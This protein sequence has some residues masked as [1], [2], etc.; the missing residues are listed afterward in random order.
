MKER[1]VVRRVADYF[2]QMGYRTETEVWVGDRS[3]DLIGWRRSPRRLISVEAKIDRWRYGLWQANL[4]R[5]CSDYAYLAVVKNVTDRIDLGPALATGVGVLAV[6]GAVE[7]ILPARYSRV[8]HPSLYHQ[9]M[10]PF[11]R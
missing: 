9:A 8:K 5:L 10:A 2:E 4:A 11:A 1:T 6:D 3:I 7:E